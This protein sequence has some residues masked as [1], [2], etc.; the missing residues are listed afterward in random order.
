M[1]FNVLSA[2][3]YILFFCCIIS[4]T[5]AFGSTFGGLFTRK[6]QK[7]ISP[8]KFIK[9]GVI[10]LVCSIIPLVLTLFV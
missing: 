10:F 8:K 4:I 9:A 6:G 5:L 7:V 2:A 3:F 1:L